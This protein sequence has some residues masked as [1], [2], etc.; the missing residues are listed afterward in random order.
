MRIL[1]EDPKI[2]RESL[3]NFLE[4]K[5]HRDF[6]DSQIKYIRSLAKKKIRFK[7]DQFIEILLEIARGLEPIGWSIKIET[8]EGFLDSIIAIPPR[9]ASLI[10]NYYSPLITDATFT[11]DKL[12]FYTLR[13]LDGEKSPHTAVL[14]IRAMEDSK[15]YISMFNF[16]KHHIP[17]GEHITLISGMGKPIKKLLILF[18]QLI[19]H[20]CIA[21]SICGN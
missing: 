14:V 17:E 10:Q 1:D 8:S 18:S 12:T 3:R 13:I 21:V 4:K 5:C 9:S 20:I 2:S 16:A 6:S 15:G 11:S 19:R 7:R